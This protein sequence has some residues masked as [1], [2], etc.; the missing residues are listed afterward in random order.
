MDRL[1]ADFIA[2]LPYA[3]WRLR[4]VIILER[5]RGE[6]GLVKRNRPGNGSTSDA[7]E[8]RRPRRSV[9]PKQIVRR[10]AKQQRLQLHPLHRNIRVE[11]T[12]SFI[13]RRA[14]GR[15]STSAERARH[16]H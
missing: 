11:R 7:G 13:A 8:K 12:L 16:L 2:S 14:S 3:A 10:I 6:L 4:L 9:R 1:K 5:S 15:R